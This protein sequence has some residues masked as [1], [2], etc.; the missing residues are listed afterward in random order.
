MPSGADRA[1]LEGGQPLGRNHDRRPSKHAPLAAACWPAREPSP[2]RQPSSAR[3]ERPTQEI[4]EV[5]GWPPTTGREA[6][7]ATVRP[8]R[9]D[10]E[11]RAILAR[12][13]PTGSRPT[14]ASW[15][16]S[17][18][19]TPC[20]ARPTR[21]VASAR[22]ATGSSTELTAYAAA[23]GG[24]MTVEIQSFVQQPVA[25]RIPVPTVISN[26]RRDARG[27]RRRQPHVRRQ[28]PLRLARHRRHERHRRRARRRRRR[29]GVAV[30][31]GAG[32][33]DGHPP[34]PTR[35]IVFA[36]VAGEEQ[37]LYG[38]TY[39]ADQYQDATA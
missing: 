2:E 15:R 24:R 18:P 16:R 33:G 12:S 27:R 29:V 17:A 6:P 13:T 30:S 36:A 35:R 14:S 28:W 4:E 38:S 8:Q 39:M 10:A 21:C 32:A 31:D 19:A 7:A 26:V 1:W 37:G 5:A 23:S 3:R 22:P 9:A 20:R 34:A 25:N 11:L